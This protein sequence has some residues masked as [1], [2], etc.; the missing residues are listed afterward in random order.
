[1]KALS[2]ELATRLR[3][4][5]A[6]STP[7]TQI[8]AEIGCTKSTV[9]RY[10][11]Q[12]GLAKSKNK[13]SWPAIRAYYEAGHSGHATRRHFGLYPKT[14]QDAIKRGDIIPRPRRAHVRT[15]DELMAAPSVRRTHLKDRLIREGLV[16]PRCA[17]CGIDRWRG[18]ALS[19]E[20]DHINGN[21]PDN[22]LVNLRLLCPNCHSQTETYSGRNANGAAAGDDRHGR[23]DQPV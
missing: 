4:L 22:R 1:M 19:L 10:A 23:L 18:Q 6:S 15:I 7:Y 17:W 13:Y 3:E 8:V 21:P 5:L 2:P 20:L 14:W 11:S 9:S 12:L 16:Q